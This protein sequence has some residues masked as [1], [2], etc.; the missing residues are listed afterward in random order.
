MKRAE[1]IL[2]WEG[3]SH[4]LQLG[5]WFWFSAGFLGAL[6]LAGLVSLFL[7][8]KL[9]VDNRALK[10]RLSDAERA[11]SGYRELEAEL[12]EM[13][14]LRAKLE[15]MLG[16][17]IELPP[18]ASP[19]ELPPGAGLGGTDAVPKGLPVKGEITRGL[20]EEH[21]GVDI[22]APLGSPVVATARG[23]VAQV[24]TD[25][26]LGL[27]VRLKHPRGYETVYGHLS[28]AYVK[29]GQEV[30]AGDLVGAVGTTGQTSGPHLHYGVF[31]D[32]KPVPW[33]STTS[34]PT[35]PAGG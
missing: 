27:F 4:R 30:L 2:L 16:A 25:R 28:R 35:P 1:L 3:G 12:A 33:D 6:L 32:G 10:A 18:M 29:P 5:R 9:A 31:K 7:A 22:A 17:N 24:D 20:S 23:V 21:P 8:V 26:V 14:R 15:G 19:E 34:T 13:R 11:L